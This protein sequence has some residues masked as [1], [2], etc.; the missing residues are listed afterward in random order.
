M[1]ETYALH[2]VPAFSS[3]VQAIQYI[4]SNEKWGA[5]VVY[6]DTDSLFVYLKG[7]TKEQAFRIGHDIADAITRLNPV[8]IKLKF[9]KVR[10]FVFQTRLA[11]RILTGMHLGLPALCF[12]GEE[13]IRWLQIRKPR[14][15]RA[16]IRCQGD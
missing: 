11:L 9:E 12:D 14:R 7:K 10:N 16:C 1:C 13:A 2:C 4:D 3:G 6:G 5:R 15:Y 8:P